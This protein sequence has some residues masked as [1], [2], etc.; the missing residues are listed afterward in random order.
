MRVATHT[1]GTNTHTRATQAQPG[2][3]ASAH[4]PM[5]DGYC[6]KRTHKQR[7]RARAR[8]CGDVRA[9]AFEGFT[10]ED[11]GLLGRDGGLALAG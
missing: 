6:Q 10:V 8:V 9:T 4:T 7:V 3:R 5:H 11:A 2:T 1:T